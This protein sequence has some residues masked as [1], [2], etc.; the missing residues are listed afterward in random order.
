MP[1]GEES[2]GIS[3]C[4]RSCR[5]EV[6]VSLL[7]EPPRLLDSRSSNSSAIRVENGG[8]GEDFRK[9]PDAD[10]EVPIFSG[11]LPTIKSLAAQPALRG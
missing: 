10:S 2:H 1:G 4:N 7:V 3:D 6:S 9:D 8:R 5:S 11:S